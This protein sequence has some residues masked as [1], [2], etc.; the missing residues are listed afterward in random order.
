[1]KVFTTA[2]IPS[3]KSTLLSTVQPLDIDASTMLGGEALHASN[4]FS[5]LLPQPCTLRYSQVLEGSEKTA[6]VCSLILLNCDW[7]SRIQRQGVVLITVAVELLAIT[8][9][10]HSGLG[11]FANLCENRRAG[12]LR[13][14]S[15]CVQ[16]LI[17]PSWVGLQQLALDAKREVDI[18]SL[19][20]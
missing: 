5:V 16:R 19:V 6:Y 20:A 11:S 10:T 13:P 1:M 2:Q 17:R 4:A 8:T 12:Y 14:C 3:L 15:G 9:V 7:S 18:E